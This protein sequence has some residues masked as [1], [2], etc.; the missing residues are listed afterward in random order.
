MRSFTISAVL[1]GLLL[2]LTASAQQL[3]IDPWVGETFT[4][5]QIDTLSPGEY[6]AIGS[7]NYQIIL[8]GNPAYV[9][10][11]VV[12]RFNDSAILWA[13]VFGFGTVL[14][15]LTV[16]LNGDILAVGSFNSNAMISR[17]DPSGNLLWANAFNTTISPLPQAFT[18][19]AVAQNGFLYPSG[20]RFV[21]GT[22]QVITYKLNAS[23]NTVWSLQQ[24]S[25]GTSNSVTV[26]SVRND[27][28]FIFG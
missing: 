1:V 8:F 23:G 18:S 15:D 21:A 9:D 12:V 16:C 20:T 10:G 22:S 25:T 28:L 11:A 3:T 14:T 5:V 24:P 6:V 19:I 17:F 13:K 27:S 26:S 4:P 2:T 7:A